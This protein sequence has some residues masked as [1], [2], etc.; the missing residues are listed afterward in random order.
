MSIE[1]K[2]VLAFIGIEADSID[3]L[4]EQFNTKYLPKEEHVKTLGELNGKLTASIKKAGKE[5]GIE[6]DATDIKDKSLTE[7]IPLF[8]ER[9]KGKFTELEGHKS[10]TAEEIEAKYKGDLSTY[11]QKVND[12]KQLNETLKSQ[13]EGFKTEVETEKK[14]FKVDSYFDGAFGKLNFAESAG[15]FAKIGFKATVSQKYRFDLNDE[16]APVVRDKE[17][18]IVQSKAKAGTAA[19]FDE[20]LANELKE[21]KLEKVVDSKKV[22]TFVPSARVVEV[23]GGGNA[24]P[25]RYQPNLLR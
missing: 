21:A 18:N 13:F 22:N 19:T 4:K 10:S 1:T 14:T 17:G 3:T 8:G 24:A 20:V 16:G 12:L 25:K 2:E 11:Q 9:V 5:V 23:K 6:L 15:D 7:I